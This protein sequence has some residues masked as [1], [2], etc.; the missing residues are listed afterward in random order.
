MLD[1]TANRVVTRYAL[2]IVRDVHPSNELNQFSD[3]YT[4][5]YQLIRHAKKLAVWG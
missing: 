1:L 5:S 2:P 3:F 4:A